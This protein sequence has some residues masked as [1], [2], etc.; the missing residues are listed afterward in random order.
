MLDTVHTTK[1]VE[2]ELSQMSASASA[3]NIQ[4]NLF[5]VS[6]EEDRAICVPL[7]DKGN[8]IPVYLQIIYLNVMVK[9]FRLRFLQE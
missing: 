8:A 9:H 4:D 7:L 5:I 3:S 1:V 2:V 6:C